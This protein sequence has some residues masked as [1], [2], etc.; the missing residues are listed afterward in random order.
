M[1]KGG[2]EEKPAA[3]KLKYLV[4][5][6]T[7]SDVSDDMT[8]VRHRQHSFDVPRPFESFEPETMP[9]FTQVKN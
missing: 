6:E 9:E 3:T 5:H 2:E 7:Y 8:T 1:E 4:P